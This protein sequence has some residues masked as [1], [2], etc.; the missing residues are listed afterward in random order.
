LVVV[1]TREP[2]EAGFSFRSVSSMDIK[3]PGLEALRSLLLE[4][5]DF[6]LLLMAVRDWA[7]VSAMPPRIWGG[8]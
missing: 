1:G 6:R 2:M 5:R 3:G 8:G 4:G 7:T